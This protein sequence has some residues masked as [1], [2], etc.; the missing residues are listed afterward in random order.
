MLKV[1]WKSFYNVMN[2]RGQQSNGHFIIVLCT[3][4]AL[5]IE[6]MR[7]KK[8]SSEAD[9]LA[10][11][12]CFHKVEVAKRHL[13]KTLFQFEENQIAYEEYVFQKA[14]ELNKESEDTFLKVKRRHHKNLSSNLPKSPIKLHFDRTFSM[15]T[16]NLINATGFALEEI[17]RSKSCIPRKWM[18]LCQNEINKSRITFLTWLR[19]WCFFTRLLCNYQ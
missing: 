18:F 9:I 19:A 16:P 2:L 10:L 14:R 6:E 7:Q 17:K 8:N 12:I 4:A 3:F 5:M 11:K 13:N 1:S 15:K